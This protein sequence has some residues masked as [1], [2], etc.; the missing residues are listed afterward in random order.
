MP[1]KMYKFKHHLGRSE[2]DT[3]NQSFSAL[4]VI[5]I[6]IEIQNFYYKCDEYFN[7]EIIYVGSLP[8]P[9]ISR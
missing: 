1:V 9:V 8:S 6:E 3:H 2:S 7:K 5:T 4:S